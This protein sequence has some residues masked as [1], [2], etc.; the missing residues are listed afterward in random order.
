[1]HQ[2]QC[3]FPSQV[4]CSTWL[5]PA[6]NRDVVYAQNLLNMYKHAL[7]CM[8]V[9]TENKA[10][11]ATDDEINEARW[12]RLRK[13]G[14]KARHSPSSSYLEALACRQLTSALCTPFRN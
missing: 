6:I 11:L 14:K 2:T 12:S 9:S 13:L 4:V 1:M 8:K 3:D 5:P 7:V 10:R